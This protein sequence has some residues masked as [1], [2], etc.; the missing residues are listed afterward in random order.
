LKPKVAHPLNRGTQ[1][2]NINARPGLCDNFLK[3]LNIS[4]TA[5]NTDQFVTV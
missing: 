3:I 5:K 1:V 4:V 2:R